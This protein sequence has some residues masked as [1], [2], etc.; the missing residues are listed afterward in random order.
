[1]LK[2]YVY[3]S[4]PKVDMLYPQI[5]AGFL[6]GPE[7]E[8]KVSLGIISSGVKSRSPDPPDEGR[9]SRN[10]GQVHL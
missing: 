10:P 3:I 9:P 6:A 4:K 1:M 2:Y 5:P 7:A 8:V